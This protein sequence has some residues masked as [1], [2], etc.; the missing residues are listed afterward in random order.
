MWDHTY[1]FICFDGLA[2][3]PADSDGFEVYSNKEITSLINF[4]IE[5]TAYVAEKGMT[6]ETWVNSAYNTG[7]YTI[8]ENP[9]SYNRVIQQ[10]ADRYANFISYDRKEVDST[11]VIV[12]GQTYTVTSS[13]F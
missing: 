10:L 1:L 6:W 12:D 4:F 11:E 2:F 3:K 5:D 7:N 8:L 13:P 9:Y